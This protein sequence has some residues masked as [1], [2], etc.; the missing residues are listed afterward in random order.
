MYQKAATKAQLGAMTVRGGL[1]LF[2]TG[3]FQERHF[4]PFSLALLFFAFR[5]NPRH[6]YLSP[7]RLCSLSND[8][9]QIMI[10]FPPICD[11]WIC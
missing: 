10:G 1:I 11:E 6:S 3:S 2:A 4:S 8:V 5:G 9:L 7:T